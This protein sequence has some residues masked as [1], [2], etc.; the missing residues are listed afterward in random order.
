MVHESWN[1]AAASPTPTLLSTGPAL[2]ACWFWLQ[3]L[4]QE[5]GHYL[6]RLGEQVSLQPPEEA[7]EHFL[8]SC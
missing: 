6:S 4:V 5:K 7:W 2:L 3:G 1:P 8:G